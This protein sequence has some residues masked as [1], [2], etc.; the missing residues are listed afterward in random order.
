MRAVEYENVATLWRDTEAFLSRDAANNTQ[1][2]SAI[3]RLLARGAHHDERYFAV[4]DDAD[5]TVVGAA[6]RVDS[7]TLFCSAMPEAAALL[8]G[9]F[10]NEHNVRLD[11]VVGECV[12]L[13]AFAKSFDHAHHVHGN[14]M[15]YQLMSG[16]NFGRAMGELRAVTMADVD[17]MVAWQRAFEIEV[18]MIRVPT[19]IEERVAAS[20]KD[21]APV[22]WIDDG[23]P[24]AMAGARKLPASSARIGPVYTPPAL[25]GRGYAQA[26]VAAAGTH[27]ARDEPRTIFLFTAAEN[28]ASNKAYQRIGYVHI[29]DHAHWIFD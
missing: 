29:A 14:M 20:I 26:I 10:L 6:V 11:G 1:A 7:K 13:D 2:L 12:V 22:F 8:L 21:G 17:L 9:E 4:R 19:P 15:L 3:A 24:V 5:E 28:P 16:P 27:V 23:V 18:N 25:R